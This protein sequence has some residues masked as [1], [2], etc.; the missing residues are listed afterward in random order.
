MVRSG[1]VIQFTAWGREFDVRGDAGVS[2]HLSGFTNESSPNGNGT[3]HTKKTRKLGGFEGLPLS[4]DNSRKDLEFLQE[5]ANAGE[6]GPF[7]ISLASGQTYAGELTIQGEINLD[8]SEGQVE[9][10]ALG[11]RFEQI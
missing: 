7:A 3:V 1:D 8:T 11:A 5:K 2:I 4:M 10:T 9:I 6:P